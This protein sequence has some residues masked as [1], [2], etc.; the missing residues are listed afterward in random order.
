MSI[1]IVPKNTE[2]SLRTSEDVYYRIFWDH[3]GLQISK[4]DVV[5]GYIDH[6]YPDSP[7]EMPFNEWRLCKEGGDIPIHHILYF[8]GKNNRILWDRRARIDSIFK[9]SGNN[10][11][12]RNST[13]F[14]K[15]CV[16]SKYWSYL[17]GLSPKNF[18]KL[19]PIVNFA[20]VILPKTIPLC[21]TSLF[22]WCREIF[23]EDD[24]FQPVVVECTRLE[25][26]VREDV[27]A[28]EYEIS[29]ICS[30]RNL[31][32]LK[33]LLSCAPLHVEIKSPT[34]IPLVS[35]KKNHAQE[36]L[37][38][39][40][41]SFAPFKFGLEYIDFCNSADEPISGFSLYDLLLTPARA[42][43]LATARQKFSQPTTRCSRS[44]TD[45][46]KSEAIIA[47]KEIDNSR[48]GVPRQHKELS[49]KDCENENIQS[50]GLIVT[51]GHA[52]DFEVLVIKR[53]G[54]TKFQLP[55]GIVKKGEN[56]VETA[57]RK[58]N[59]ETGLELPEDCKIADSESIT[60]NY[61]TNKGPQTTLFFPAYL[62]SGDELKFAYGKESETISVEFVRLSWL[63]DKCNRKSSFSFKMFKQ[64]KNFLRDKFSTKKI[65]Q[66]VKEDKGLSEKLK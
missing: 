5:I 8:V 46:S 11:E 15:L 35:V 14:L 19:P 13:L 39:M 63:T 9:N 42:G 33:K 59:E 22:R 27:G 60:S 24:P 7:R 38:S 1:K 25:L 48:K 37:I 17:K 66:T 54:Y 16:P 2:N 49:M 57:K 43:F 56:I 53:K 61:V 29:A 58:F 64:Y 23:G 40:I 12:W 32:S 3:A 62:A 51:R 44:T 10:V 41:E 45:K 4:E 55:N 20:E 34:K 26:G 65:E 47:E 6:L 18:K 52:E 28:T 36:V 50:A 31:D 30:G 21:E